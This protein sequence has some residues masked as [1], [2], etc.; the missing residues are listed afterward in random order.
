MTTTEQ[1][2]L[3][4][5]LRVEDEAIAIS[6][7]LPLEDLGRVGRWQDFVRGLSCGQITVVESEPRR[8]VVKALPEFISVDFRF[9][10]DDSIPP[11]R[12]R[13]N[14]EDD[15][16]LSRVRWS[17][18]LAARN[19]GVV[20]GAT[21]M[22][23]VSQK[24]LPTV[25][26]LHT[27]VPDDIRKDVTTVLLVG[28]MLAC[29]GWT[30]PPGQS[31]VKLAYEFL[32]R[33]PNEHRSAVLG[34][35]GLFRS[36][37][38]TRMGVGTESLETPCL[39]VNPD[40]LGRLLCE[41][42]AAMSEEDLDERLTR[43][44][45]EVWDRDGDGDCLD[46]RSLFMDLLTHR[47]PERSW[48]MLPLEAVKKAQDGERTGEV[49]A[50]VEDIKRAV[51]GGY[52]AAAGVVRANIGGVLVNIKDHSHHFVRLL[53]VV[54][55]VLE[56]QIKF[57]DDFE[58]S[59]TS[60]WDS[61]TDQRSD[62]EAHPILG[63]QIRVLSRAMS[64]MKDR[65]K[66][67]DA[68]ADGW[69]PLTGR[70]CSIRQ[71][72]HLFAATPSEGLDGDAEVLYRILRY[73]EQ[74][75]E[76]LGAKADAGEELWVEEDLDGDDDVAALEGSDLSRKLSAQR[77]QIVRHLLGHMISAGLIECVERPVITSKGKTRT[78]PF[79]RPLGT[80]RRD[81]RVRLV[82]F[83]ETR[84]ADLLGFNLTARGKSHSNQISRIIE[85]AGYANYKAFRTRLR[86]GPTPAHIS[87]AAR[88]Y[89]ETYYTH[90]SPSDWPPICTF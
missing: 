35:V 74:E 25:T 72:L 49:L 31:A 53:G 29:G 50:W 70:P 34:T 1:P 33:L 73:E 22:G 19:A 2:R 46:L 89:M 7:D 80:S 59:L 71:A 56:E 78:Q 87:Q 41:F 30:F 54:F 61:L 65:F 11:M 16:V 79:Y 48:D 66:P 83:D 45:L 40:S 26:T 12:L 43:V 55:A 5:L 64:D 69:W 37:L 67:G 90:V 21:L 77:T 15:P 18:H 84:I 9:H 4:R 27:L 8:R 32:G 57:T 44:G 38:A 76:A 6:K 10:E 20:I 36:R 51:G 42:D 14:E 86:S 23:I 63:Q 47:H 62:N 82:Y 85:D 52:E 3:L 13:G 58:V 81:L 75:V 68:P 28:Q 17:E 88:W 60:P 39:F 24:D